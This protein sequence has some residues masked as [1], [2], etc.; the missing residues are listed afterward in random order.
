M[1]EDF[2]SFRRDGQAAGRMHSFAGIAQAV[3]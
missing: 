2:H 3:Q 1:P